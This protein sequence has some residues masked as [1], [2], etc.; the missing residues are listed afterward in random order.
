MFNK[1]NFYFLNIFRINIYWMLPNKGVM[2]K[3]I[4]KISIHSTPRQKQHKNKKL[5]NLHH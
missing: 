4:L 3:W 5:Y 1:G 2:T